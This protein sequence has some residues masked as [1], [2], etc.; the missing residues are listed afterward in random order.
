[1]FKNQDG[2]LPSMAEHKDQIKNSLITTSTTRAT[3][4]RKNDKNKTRTT[5][6]REQ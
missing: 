4:M 5:I 6:T 2:W 3:T 1:M